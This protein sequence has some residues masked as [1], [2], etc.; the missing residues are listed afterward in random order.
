MDPMT[1][2]V[3]T[4]A[5]LEAEEAARGNGSSPE[6]EFSFGSR[7]KIL[8]ADDTVYDV[9]IIPEWKM[10]ARVRSLTSGERDVWE[11]L[12]VGQLTEDDFKKH[13][14]GVKLGPQHTRALVVYY[15]T[16]AGAEGNSRMFPDPNDI[17]VLA[18]KH[19][20]P[21]TRLFMAIIKASAVTKKDLDELEEGF[22][23]D[24]TSAPSTD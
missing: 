11:R 3:P 18:R 10:K 17:L 20:A 19:S 22:R 7:Q 23:T 12:S 5:T 21:V 6:E 14:K 16:L 1:D 8:E 13:F 24:P 2:E 4:G 9:V 15:G